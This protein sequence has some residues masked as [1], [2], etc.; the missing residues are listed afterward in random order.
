MPTLFYPKVE[1]SP[2]RAR[3]L[4][5]EFSRELIL[6]QLRHVRRNYPE[7]YKDFCDWHRHRDLI[8]RKE[9]PSKERSKPVPTVQAETKWYSDGSA[10]SARAA[11]TLPTLPTLPRLIAVPI[12]CGTVPSSGDGVGE[13]I[14]PQG[15]SIDLDVAPPPP[16]PEPYK[17]PAQPT[18]SIVDPLV[19]ELRALIQQQQAARGRP[20]RE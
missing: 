12:M 9:T 3:A 4:D 11:P 1:E 13:L 18:I 5:D 16:P 2:L 19:A 10:G 6:A 15:R 14:N 7:R 20:L 17:P 8:Q